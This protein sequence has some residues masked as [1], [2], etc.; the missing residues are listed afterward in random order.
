MNFPLYLRAIE[1][2]P[3]SLSLS[4]TVTGSTMGMVWLDTPSEIELHFVEELNHFDY[5][6]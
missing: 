4:S 2:D 5:I 1:E 6:R 3:S